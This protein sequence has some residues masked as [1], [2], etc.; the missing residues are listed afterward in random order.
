MGQ[1][2]LVNSLYHRN[3]KTLQEITDKK[4]N[5]VSYVILKDNLKL[6]VA[7]FHDKEQAIKFLN[8]KHKNKQ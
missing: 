2:T 6:P 1:K 7:Y 4:N 3:K 5:K 8:K